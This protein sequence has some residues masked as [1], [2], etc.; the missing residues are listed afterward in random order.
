MRE[1]P[2]GIEATCTR[3]QGVRWPTRA[4]QD[5]APFVCHRCRAVLAGRNAADPRDAPSE[6]QRA[7][8]V[9]AGA[10]LTLTAAGAR[11]TAA[12]TA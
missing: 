3:C 9:A 1:Q 12:R 4:G 2:I 6:A 8:R 7:A 11:L 10:R 5:P